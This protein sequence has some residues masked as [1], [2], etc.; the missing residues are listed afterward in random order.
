VTTAAGPA[1][2]GAPVPSLRERKKQRTRQALIDTALE[3]FTRRGFDT[4]T[5]DELCEAVEVSK[6]TFFRNFTSK[7]DVATTPFQDFWTAFL[8]EL[9]VT[10]PA[11]RPLL[12]L[13][14]DALLSTLDR[15]TDPDW[16]RRFRLSYRL[17][18]EN[19]SVDAHGLHLGDRTAR[20]ALEILRRRFDVGGPADPRPRLAGDMLIAA[21]RYALAG[22]DRQAEAARADVPGPQADPPATSAGVPPTGG[23]PSTAKASWTTRPGRLD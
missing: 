10:G 7:E 23:P 16:A 21:F 20:A 2:S 15:R 14:R 4:V 13:L 17:S 19:P 18:V 3:Q 6:R 9:E 1:A 11:G 5:L 12:E 22:W 8:A